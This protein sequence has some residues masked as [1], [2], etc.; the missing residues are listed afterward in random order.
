VSFGD[1][2]LVS[3]RAIKVGNL[4]QGPELTPSRLSQLDKMILNFDYQVRYPGVR[5]DNADIILSSAPMPDSSRTAVPIDPI[6][7]SHL[8]EAVDLPTDRIMN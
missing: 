7:F 1:L 5:M 4:T 8:S 3:S 6:F 2:M